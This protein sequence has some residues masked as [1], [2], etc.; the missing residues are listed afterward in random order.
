MKIHLNTNPLKSINNN[1]LF[2]LTAYKYPKGEKLQ[3]YVGI[4]ANVSLTF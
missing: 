3:S 1:I 2:P 4:Y